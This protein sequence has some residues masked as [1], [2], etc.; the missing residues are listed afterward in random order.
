VGE[1]LYEFDDLNF[2]LG[3]FRFFILGD[4]FWWVWTWISGIVFF[5]KES[6]GNGYLFLLFCLG[7]FVSAWRQFVWV[8]DPLL[9]YLN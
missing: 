6:L 3:V 4:E 8:Y 5:I 9:G 1:C 2:T 7:L